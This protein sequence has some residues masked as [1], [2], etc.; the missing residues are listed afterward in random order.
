MTF[1]ATV[2]RLLIAS[3]TDT[4][5]ARQVIRQA[6]E[7][8]NSLHAE[9]T[10]VI[11]LPLMWERD[12]VPEMGERPQLIINR[13]LVE[14]ADLLVGTFWTRLGTPTGESESGTAEEIEEC[15]AAGKPVLIYFSSEPVV[16]SS[17][18]QDEYA[19]LAAFRE[20]LKA[21]GLFDE[22]RSEHELYRKVQAALTRTMRER[23]RAVAVGM[24]DAA[25]LPAGDPGPL[26]RPLGRIEREREMTGVSRQGRPR[27][28]TRERLIIENRGT[29]AAEELSL[30]FQVPEGLDGDPPRSFGDDSPVR[31]LPPG[32]AIEFPLMTHAGV[33]MHWEIVFRWNEGGKTFEDVQT[34][35]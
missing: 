24:Q 9:E 8:W 35:G 11:L 22:Y 23:F 20:K 1:G 5:T 10:G 3:P 34:L 15:I 33:A 4:G 21:Q 32:G 26:A 25:S 27:Y 31:R 12:A 17:V 18:N 19:R 2:A 14:V 7:D 16:L 6:A 30:P 13:Q 29:G 28:R